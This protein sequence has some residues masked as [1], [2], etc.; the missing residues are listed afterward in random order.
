MR[1]LQVIKYDQNDPEIKYNF[2]L[3]FGPTNTYDNQIY[4]VEAIKQTI[5]ARCR[6]IR[7]ELK[8]DPKLGVPLG[9]D[10]ETTGLLIQDIIL[11]TNGVKSC[12][13]LESK[14]NTKTRLF[15]YNFEI[16]TTINNNIINVN[17]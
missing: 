12:R 11:S 10:A 14:F 9:M 1:A 17:I 8:Y 5:E 2:D 4:D 16:E 6:V 13:L 15:N 7:G 3:L